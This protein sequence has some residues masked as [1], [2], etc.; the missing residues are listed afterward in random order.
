MVAVLLLAVHLH[1][2]H[3]AGPRPYIFS[4]LS[5]RLLLLNVLLFI[6]MLFTVV[7]DIVDRLFFPYGS[8]VCGMGIIA[9]FFEVRNNKIFALATA[10]VTLNSLLVL[11]LVLAISGM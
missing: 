5:L 3:G 1:K 9:A 6:I 8:I 2:N 7:P 11:L 10:T 4:V